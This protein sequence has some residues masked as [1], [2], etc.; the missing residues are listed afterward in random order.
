M[1]PVHPSV[2][3]P[4]L[5]DVTIVHWKEDEY[6]SNMKK[7]FDQHHREKALSTLNPDDQVYVPDTRTYGAVCQ[8]ANTPRSYI[9]RTRKGTLH[10]N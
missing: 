9:I 7:T 5:P 4:K 10:R 8:D 1:L 2:L 6:R 3:T